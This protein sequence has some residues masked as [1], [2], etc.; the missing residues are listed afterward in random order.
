AATR[1]MEAGAAASEEQGAG[2]DA[3]G[4]PRVHVRQLRA[5]LAVHGQQSAR[6]LLDVGDAEAGT[7]DAFALV[8]VESED[9]RR[10][11]GHGAGDADE[12]AWSREV[13][14]LRGLVELSID[15]GNRRPDLLLVG[16]L[17]G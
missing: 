12:G 8:A 4:A 17:H 16:G 10:H 15:I 11:C 7:V 2:A 9:S 14:D 13:D 3:V 6:L 1:M 5:R